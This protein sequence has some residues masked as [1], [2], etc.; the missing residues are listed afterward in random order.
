MALSSGEDE[1]YAAVKGA[2]EGLGF[3]AGFADLG[4]WANGTVA[5]RVLTDSGACGE[6]LPENRPCEDS[7]HRCCIPVASGFGAKRQNPDG[8]NPR[9][10]ELK[11]LPG[12]NVA[13]IS[14]ARVSSS[15]AVGVTSS[16][17]P[18]WVLSESGG[19]Q[20]GVAGAEEECRQHRQ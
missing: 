8:Q 3:L 14:R 5:L 18:M 6:D 12:M 1:Y 2:S 20:R 10:G 4:N 9:K 15:R 16:M 19:S 7:T 13:E 17:P 11:C